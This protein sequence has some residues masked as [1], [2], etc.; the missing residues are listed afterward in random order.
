MCGRMYLPVHH[1][2]IYLSAHQSI[3][4]LCIDLAIHLSS[5]S[6][7]LGFCP[8][9]PDHA[10]CL[11]VHPSGLCLSEFHDMVPPPSSISGGISLFPEVPALRVLKVM[12]PPPP[13]P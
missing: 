10:P 7:G 6:L 2:F 5:L 4:Y 9:V 1:L 13:K 11:P 8:E 12:T 3:I